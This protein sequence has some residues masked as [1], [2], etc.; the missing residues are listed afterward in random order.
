MEG[1]EEGEEGLWRWSN[2]SNS[3]T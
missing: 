2:G 1:C 3:G